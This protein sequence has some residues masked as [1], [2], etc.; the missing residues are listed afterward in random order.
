LRRHASGELARTAALR[1]GERVR[2]RRLG[3]HE[4]GRAVRG[5][6][7][8]RPQV[9]AGRE[10]GRAMSVQA[11]PEVDLPAEL[12]T[13]RM[14]IGGEWVA[15]A[16]GALLEVENPSRRSLLATVPR[17]GEEDCDRAV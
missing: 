4:R 12:E 2:S 15:A 13:A 6:R 16:S 11:P 10:G 17:A 9:G 7:R 8:R 1:R 3:L 14:L 5:V